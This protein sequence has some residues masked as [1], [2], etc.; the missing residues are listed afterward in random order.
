MKENTE[1]NIKYLEEQEM[2]LVNNI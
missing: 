1:R 2:L